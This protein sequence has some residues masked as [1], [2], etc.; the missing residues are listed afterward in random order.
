MRSI[1]VDID[2]DLDEIYDNMNRHDKDDMVKLLEDEGYIE[3]EEVNEPAH[4]LE[5]MFQDN[6]RKLMNNYHRLS[7]EQVEYIN[8]LTKYL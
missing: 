7:T 8:Q 3:K 5:D 6:V 2:F 1:S 4:L